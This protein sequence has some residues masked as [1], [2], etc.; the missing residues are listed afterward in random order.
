VHDESVERVEET[1][2]RQQSDHSIRIKVVVES[3]TER[4]VNVS[5]YAL[6]RLD[7][8]GETTEEYRRAAISGAMSAMNDADAAGAVTILEVDYASAHSTPEEVRVS[9]LIATS[10]ALRRLGHSLT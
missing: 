10:L 2:V 8:Q 1:Y 5:P 4:S 3:L 7:G 6:S 9:T